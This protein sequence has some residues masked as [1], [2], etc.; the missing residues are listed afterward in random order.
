MATR[1][2]TRRPSRPSSGSP[3][4]IAGHHDTTTVDQGAVRAALARTAAR[5]KPG[6]ERLQPPEVRTRSRPAVRRRTGTSDYRSLDLASED[7]H[8]PD[9]H[10]HADREAGT[11][12]RTTTTR[13]RHLRGRSR[14]GPS[15]RPRSTGS[16]WPGGDD[17]HGG[18]PR[19]SV[20]VDDSFTLPDAPKD[21]PRHPQPTH[22]GPEEERVPTEAPPGEER[23]KRSRREDPSER[24]ERRRTRPPTGRAEGGHRLPRV[25]PRAVHGFARRVERHRGITGRAPAKVGRK[26]G[27]AGATEMTDGH[28][29]GI[30]TGRPAVDR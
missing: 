29:L 7:P 6:G 17:A 19:G 9:E 28:A 12:C 1:R 3:R 23:G 20:T 18:S 8:A 22:Q 13:R 4:A 11:P 26:G 27:A 5:K 10:D 14:A 30:G 25:T 2:R 24:S 15:M 16:P 21:D